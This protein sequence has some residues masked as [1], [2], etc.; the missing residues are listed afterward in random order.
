MKIDR[1]DFLTY[2]TAAVLGGAAGTLLTPAPWKLMDDVAIWT[3]NWPWTPVPEA[4][5]VSHKKSICTLCPGGCGIDVRFAGNRPVKIDGCKDHPINQGSLCPMGLSGLQYLHGPDRV[6]APMK[7]EGKRGE[8]KWKKIS[9]DEA[10][11]AVTEKLSQL[12]MTGSPQSLACITTSQ[13][14]MLPRLIE[15]FMTAYGSPN[16]LSAPT[17]FDAIG[18]AGFLTQGF[19]GTPFFDLEHADLILS[20]GSGLLEGWGNPGRMLCNFGANRRTQK[21]IQVEPRLSDT[22]AQAAQWIAINPGTEGALALGLC[23]IIINNNWQNKAFIEA[24]T[25]GFSEW[26]DENGQ[27][28]KGFT[29]LCEDYPPEKTSAVTGISQDKLLTLAKEFATAAHPVAVNGRG[30]GILPGSLSESL[31]VMSLNALVGNIGQ[32]GGVSLMPAPLTAKWPEPVMDATASQGMRQPRIDGAGTAAFPNSR[33]L[34]N[35]L[36]GVI[37]ASSGDSPIQALLVAEANPLYTLPDVAAT[38][39]ALDR[40]PFIVSFSSYWDETAGFSDYIL[41][42]ST[43]LERF[44]D[45]AAPISVNRWIIGLSKP[46]IQP[47]H[48]TRHCGDAFIQ[49][50]KGLGGGI[51]DAF[52][53]ETH[54]AC[55]EE[56]Y[57]DIWAELKEKGWAEIPVGQTDPDAPLF[58][59][60]SGKFEF[61]PSP[62]SPGNS[63]GGPLPAYV[64]IAFEGNPARFPLMLTPVDL[65]RLS[66]GPIANAPFMTKT[67]DDT[68]LK[69]QIGFVE[70]NPD[71]A[72]RL[73][74]RDGDTAL[75]TTPK[76]RATVRIHLYEGLQRG[77]IAMHRGLG[78]TAGSEFLAGKGANVN[79]LTA[80]VEDPVSG[81]DMAWGTRA[82][83]SRI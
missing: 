75:L 35:R 66:G 19:Q 51:A 56:A 53:W 16:L 47:L 11:S 81:Y 41:P 60:T 28:H 59:T 38:Q 30:S 40:I 64:P 26:A 5:P 39:K 8:G 49:I 57:K 2:T 12:R 61:S 21:I 20:F 6:T 31:A 74:F 7:R 73:D 82:M 71:T 70:I 34:L 32:P 1:R 3:Q 42:H 45:I 62:M 43:F 9:W 63:N 14:G 18:Q 29:A 33:S 24:Q 69:E 46:V 37:T 15:R 23:H 25:F 67:I 10:I 80:P 22:A 83:L 17:A 72:K 58:H 79:A 36:P 68:I 76:G 4:G 55:L 50:A 65:I 27:P 54:E 52:Y 44:Q 77:L 78:H 48:D 13:Q